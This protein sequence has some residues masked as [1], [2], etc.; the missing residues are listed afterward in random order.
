MNRRERLTPTR[1]TRYEK[2]RAG[3]ATRSPKPSSSGS[4]FPFPLYLPSAL[5]ITRVLRTKH[6]DGARHGPGEGHARQNQPRQAGCRELFAAHR[7]HCTPAAAQCEAARRAASRGVSR[8]PVAIIMVTP[9]REELE[10]LTVMRLKASQSAASSILSCTAPKLLG[11]L[12]PHCQRR[13]RH[14]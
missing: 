12:R 6:V 3:A 10:S 13:R 14:R 2:Q 11:S 1:K 4:A 7:R 5:S 9:Q 8:E